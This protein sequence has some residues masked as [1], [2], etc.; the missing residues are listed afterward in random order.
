MY[1]TGAVKNLFGLVPNL[2]KSPC[3]V[4]F[5]TRGQFA[6][7]MVGIAAVVAPSFSLM[8]GII[9]MEPRPPTA[10]PGIWDFY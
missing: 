7:L 9:G 2:F 8:D 1:T 10:G 4:Q 3:H 5:P 6:S